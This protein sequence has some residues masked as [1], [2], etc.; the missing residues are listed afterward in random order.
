MAKDPA[1]LWYWD[2]WQGGTMTLSRHLKGCYIDLLNAQFNQGH[3]SLEEIK[4]VLGS[5][6][7]SSWPT[8]QKKF[9]QDH[10]GLFFN[11]RAD[12][13]KNK[14]AA[15]TESRRNNLKGE[16]KKPHKGN[17][18]GDHMGNGNEDGNKISTGSKGVQGDGDERL[19]WYEQVTDNIIENNSA[20][21]QKMF[22]NE[23]RRGLTPEL[24]VHLVRDH[25]GLLSRYPAMRPPTEY[26]FVK[27]LIKHIQENKVKVKN[28][29]Q[30]TGI[31]GDRLNDLIETRY[32]SKG[33]A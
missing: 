5:D 9:K 29:K 2:N 1:T 10:N 16:H 31:D 20:M 32:G 18:M 14:R 19:K 23:D 4:T 25:L 3:L 30:S 8:L 12:L 33:T 13:E 24:F 22:I 11:E 6:F 7:G 26:A 21:F 27:S 15:F 17:Q 28:G